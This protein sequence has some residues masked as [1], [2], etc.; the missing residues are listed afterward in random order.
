MASVLPSLSAPQLEARLGSLFWDV[1]C[2][3]SGRFLSVQL[4]LDRNFSAAPDA[5][6]NVHAFFELKPGEYFHL[7][8]Y[9]AHMLM[10][11]ERTGDE[12]FLTGYLQPHIAKQGGAHSLRQDW[13]RQ[14]PDEVA[15]EILEQNPERFVLRG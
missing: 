8:A 2:R 14:D 6:N 5:P 4:M 10:F 13:Y 15:R 7:R 9:T 11:P 1:A 12:A 3:L